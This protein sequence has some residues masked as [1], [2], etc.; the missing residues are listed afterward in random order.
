MTQEYLTY[1]SDT[2]YTLFSGKA[3]HINGS[4]LT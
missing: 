3:I 1:Q 4:V 2:I